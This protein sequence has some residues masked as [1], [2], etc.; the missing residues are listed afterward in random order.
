MIDLNPSYFHRRISLAQWVSCVYRRHYCH[1]YG[2][3]A[4]KDHNG[5]LNSIDQHSVC[6]SWSYS[7]FSA[8]LPLLNDTHRITPQALSSI[9][10]SIVNPN[11]HQPIRCCVNLWEPR[12]TLAGT[13]V[14]K[15]TRWGG[16]GLVIH[17]CLWTVS[18]TTSRWWGWWS[19]AS[20]RRRRSRSG[21]ECRL[22]G[23]C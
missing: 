7:L 21:L 19:K 2:G 18:Q 23:L 9:A 1:I 17:E 16:R 5:H 20:R 22:C 6:L 11:G 10:S 14:D 12:V 3:M 15:Y 8:Q 13:R 4:I